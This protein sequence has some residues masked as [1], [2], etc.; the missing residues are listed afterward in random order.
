[1]VKQLLGCTS[2]TYEDAYELILVLQVQQLAGCKPV[3]VALLVIGEH[4][5]VGVEALPHQ[6]LEELLLHAALIHPL[7]ANELDLA[8]KAG[9]KGYRARGWEWCVCRK[10]GET[11]VHV[12]GLCRR[13]PMNRGVQVAA[14]AGGMA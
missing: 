3:Q 2:R 10:Q 9:G 1:V 4:A 12:C 14:L 5:K 8:G 7:L 6:E 13:W 11:G